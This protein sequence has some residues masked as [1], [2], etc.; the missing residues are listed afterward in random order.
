MTG[1]GTRAHRSALRGR[2]HAMGRP[3]SLAASGGWER[4]AGSA[5]PDS[6]AWIRAARSPRETTGSRFPCGT[7]AGQGL[8][9]GSPKVN[10]EPVTKDT[11][12]GFGKVPKDS[13]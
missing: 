1:Q 6:C 10:N 5:P 3:A 13:E 12:P 2:G 8:G 11:N 4:G 7:Q 9:T